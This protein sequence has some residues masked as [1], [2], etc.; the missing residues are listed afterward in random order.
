MKDVAIKIFFIFCQESS[1]PPIYLCNEQKLTVTS[2]L[3]TIWISTWKEP[4]WTSK[5]SLLRPLPSLP[6]AAPKWISHRCNHARK[7]RLMPPSKH[8]LHAQR[9]SKP[10]PKKNRHVPKSNKSKSCPLCQDYFI[11]T[12]Q[13]MYPCVLT[14]HTWMNGHIYFYFNTPSLYS[15][16]KDSPWK[17]KPSL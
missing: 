4:A 12:T 9:R 11:G 1:A 15:P 16:W 3:S 2:F 5:P 17:S 14:Q 8:K 6:P 10:A 13:P 7:K